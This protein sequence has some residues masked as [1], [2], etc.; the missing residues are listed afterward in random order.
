[1]LIVFTLLLG[2][3]II[4]L[5]YFLSPLFLRKWIV[6]EQ[7]HSIPPGPS[8]RYA[9][10]RKYA[11]QAL[12]DWTNKFGPLFLLWMGSQL[13]IVVSDP[14]I[15]RD[16]FVTNGAIFSNRKK[17]FM[18]NQ[19]QHR[20]L[21]TMVL[22]P[23]AMQGYINIM[24]YE[25]HIF[26]KSLYDE[27]IRGTSAINP[28]HYAGRFALNNMLIISFGLRTYSTSDPLI[29][30]ALYLAME[31]MDLTGPW[32]NSVD[33][34]EIL[35]RIP[36]RTRSRGRNLHD[37]L[38]S[39][40]G[41]MI[42][43]FKARM[44][45]GEEV[46]DCLVKTLLETQN[47]EKLD[48]EDLCMLSAIFTLG[49]VHSTSGIIL[50]FL[51]L[52]PSHPDILI[53]AHEELDRVIGRNRWPST[54]DEPD[55]PYVRAIIKEVQRV[56]APFWMATPHFNSQDFVY[57]GTYIP[58]DTV[59]VLNCYSLHHNE[60]C[61]PDSFTFNPDRYLGDELSCSESVKHSDVMNRDHWTFGAGRRICP[62]IPGA[63]RELWLAIVRL[64]WAYNFEAL[65]EEPIS[66]Q[67][68]EG[69]SGRTPVPFR[70]RFIPRTTNLHH[71]LKT[72]DEIVL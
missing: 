25:A 63:E 53:R 6:D 44:D 19:R 32:S 58:K 33:F 59:L 60:S 24:E 54:E 26:I 52:I 70:L 62:G 35:Q 21:A 56:H 9:F 55:L 50:W 4:I 20:R 8:I 57:R 49:G 36:T 72:A 47:K 37:G 30:K 18:K 1:M 31:F 5:V 3:L 68:Y 66:L 11:E 38:I 27:G 17:Y 34:F 15:A 23:K 45:A 61:Y 67:E 13:F 12:Y 65:P 40:Y 14:Q 10:L 51:A 16:L 7:G 43:Q 39:V 29:A 22:T 46:P 42:L 28:A 64:L 71:I 2:P 48:W 41:D 69:M